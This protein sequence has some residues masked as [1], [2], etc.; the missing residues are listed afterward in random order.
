MKA[1]G[2]KASEPFWRKGLDKEGLVADMAQTLRRAFPGVNFAFSQYIQDNVQEAASGID[3]ENAIKITG[4]DLETLRK[5]AVEIRGVLEKVALA[6]VNE[7]R[8][9]RRWNMVFKFALLAY[10]FVVLMIAL[11]W[12]KRDN[13][14]DKHT[15]LVEVNGVIAS[16]SAASAA[17]SLA[18]L[19]G[20]RRVA[21]AP[22][23]RTATPAESYPRYS[24]RLSP[25]MRSGVTFR[26]PT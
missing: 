4:P 23:S 6:A 18:I 7:Q 15:A 11:G 12:L 26:G 19:P 5:I 24:M 1:D 9:A 25:S 21:S 2:R 17:S 20:A 3:A 8:T 16:G 10:L 14:P 13:F 22:L